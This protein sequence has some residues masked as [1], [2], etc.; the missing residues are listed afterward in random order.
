M[1]PY[2]CLEE[3]TND[4]FR[5]KLCDTGPMNRDILNV[6]L[7]GKQHMRKLQHRR[8][9]ELQKQNHRITTTL[10]YKGR[11]DRLRHPVWR[12][13]VQS[14]LF[15]F[16]TGT[17][18]IMSQAPIKRFLAK[19]ELMEITSLLEL[20]ILKYAICDNMT[21]STMQEVHDY[22][23]LDGSFDRRDFLKTRRIT[24]GAGSIIPLVIEFLPKTKI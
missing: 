11:I 5:C 18:N 4:R 15:C 10:T 13:H 2:Y 9:L 23:A 24:C 17:S 3:L 6:H 16:I 14:L 19:Y 20:A 1:P 21:F 22:R 8:P 12:S 7:N